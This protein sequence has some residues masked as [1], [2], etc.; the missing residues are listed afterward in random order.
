MK[1]Q[2]VFSGNPV[3]KSAKGVGVRKNPGKLKQG[4]RMAKKKPSKAQLAARANFV[5]KFAKKNPRSGKKKKVK[6]NMETVIARFPV[7]KKK[8]FKRPSPKDV[9]K[10]RQAEEMYNSATA[11]EKA[12]YD[13]LTPYQREFE[14]SRDWKAT[15]RRGLAAA[16]HAAS[17][18]KAVRTK[19]A[20][21]IAQ[22][23]LWEAEIKA[24]KEGDNVMVKE[25]PR[26]RRKKKKARRGKRSSKKH[27]MNPRRKRRKHAKRRKHR[28]ARRNPADYGMVTAGN[29]RRKR[30]KHKA[31]RRKH[32]KASLKEIEIAMNPRRRRRKKA[33]YLAIGSARLTR[34]GKKRMKRR[35]RFVL[36]T[37]KNPDWMGVVAV[38][39][40]AVLGGA[41]FPFWYYGINKVVGKLNELT[42]G[43]SGALVAKVDAL[44]PGVAAPGLS[45]AL[46]LLAKVYVLPKVSSKLGDSAKYL[47]GAID[48]IA[49]LSAAGVGQ[50]V[51]AKLGAT[52]AALGLSGVKYFPTMAGADF[53]YP[54]MGDGYKQQ[55]GDFGNVKFFPA[56]TMSG[57]E[58][59]P[60]GSRGD[61]MYR[62]SMATQMAEA[63]GLGIIP[64]GL[65]GEMGII[66][67]GLGEDPGQMG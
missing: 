28:K 2:Y 43:Q 26:K 35:S 67:E 7:Y 22:Q 47:D 21:G 17:R 41:A 53:G 24:L 33:K 29:P 62:S 6:R 61:E 1:L 44:A 8:S 52:P 13:S 15:F 25:N 63:E 20:K 42:K 5:K 38:Y 16:K 64:E 54:Q 37:K 50:A 66:P 55:P 49:V 40:T 32:R 31:R 48:T 27:A 3:K 46:A 12:Y 18:T 19:R 11:S 57:V 56:N 10:A 36:A 23:R 65:G 58:F 9:T 30:R 60:P 51:A 45:L 14:L 4:G 34:S 59:Y 39:S